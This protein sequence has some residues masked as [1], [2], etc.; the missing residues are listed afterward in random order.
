MTISTRLYELLETSS[1]ITS[2]TYWASLL[3]CFNRT[4]HQL[5][6]EEVRKVAAKSEQCR[7]FHNTPRIVRKEI[8]KNG[9]QEVIEVLVSSLNINIQDVNPNVHQWLAHL[10]AQIEQEE[11][12]TLVYNTTPNYDVA[13]MPLA[14]AAY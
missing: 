3:D 9:K 12:D 10:E 4:K 14:A 8:I 6:I 7:K 1:D 13:E 2:L 11:E 5:T